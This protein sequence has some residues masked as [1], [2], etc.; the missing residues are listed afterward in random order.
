MVAAHISVEDSIGKRIFLALNSFQIS[1][2]NDINIWLSKRIILIIKDTYFK[3][4]AAEYNLVIRV[5]KFKIG[6]FKVIK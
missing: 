2:V 6:L 3:I 1:L 4:D 5:K